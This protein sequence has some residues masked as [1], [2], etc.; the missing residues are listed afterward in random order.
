MP[1]NELCESEIFSFYISLI[2]TKTSH[3]T[4]H[5]ETYKLPVRLGHLCC[6]GTGPGFLLEREANR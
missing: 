3:F 1:R 4:Y 6:L 2:F 5:Y